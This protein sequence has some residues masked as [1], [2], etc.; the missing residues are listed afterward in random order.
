[1]DSKPARKKVAPFRV[2]KKR[3]ETS[4]KNHKFESFN[5]RIA[6]L[7]IDPI[8]RE[9]GIDDDDLS[10][11]HTH[12]QAALEK[13]AELNLSE[14]YV[15]FAK[16]VKPLCESLP[17]LLHH[18]D[19]IAE[20]LIEAIEQG[21]VI[22]V[23]PL[24]DLVANLAQDL[25]ERIERHIQR[26]ATTVV[27]LS[28]KHPEAEVAEWSFN[29]LTWLFKYLEKLLVPDLRPLYT[30]LAPFLG[31]TR[32]KPY[33]ARFTAESLSFLVRKA[34]V[35]YHINQ[36]PLHDIVEAILGDLCDP[37]SQKNVEMYEQGVVVLFAESIKGAGRSLYSKG[38]AVFREL[39]TTVYRL[40]NED[41]VMAKPAVEVLKGVFLSVLHHTEPPT[42]RP[43]LSILLEK[44][45]IAD[46]GVTEPSLILSAQLILL[47]SSTRKGSRVED[48]SLVFER[49]SG[50][51][52]YLTSRDATLFADASAQVLA[53]F[54][55][56]HQACA[57]DAAIS[58]LK[59]FD[60]ISCS[61]WQDSF[62]GFCDF[63]AEL[64]QDR[65]R[66][67]LL[68]HFQKF[69]TTSWAQCR[70]KLAALIPK[71]AHTGFLLKNSIS[72]P[73]SWQAEIGNQFERLPKA[74][75]GLRDSEVF[76]YNALVEL[77]GA[78]SVE[79]ALPP[80]VS[81]KVYGAL[82]TRLG[83]NGGDITSPGFR[84]LFVVGNGFRYAAA[85]G[86][87]DEADLW[88]LLS[89]LS[90]QFRRYHAFWSSVATFL[91]VRQPEGTGPETEA[92]VESLLESLTSPSH[93]VRLVA[94]EI[95]QT[96]T[97]IR[98]GK[99]SAALS[100]AISIETMPLTLDTARTISMQLRNLASNYV[101]VTADPW[102]RRA[103]PKF[104]FGLL[105]VRMAQ[106]W[107]DSCQALK[108][109]SQSKEGED[110][111]CETAFQWLEAS[112]DDSTPTG[113]KGFRQP[114][115]PQSNHQFPDEDGMV[116]LIHETL[117][118]RSPAV[119]QLESLFREI[120]HPARLTTPFN[121]SQA[122]RVLKAVPQI[123]EKR[124][125]AI[126]PTLLSWAL[127]MDVDYEPEEGDSESPKVPGSKGNSERWSRK[128]QKGM[129][130]LFALFTNPK[131]LYRSA[132]VY[133]ALLSLLEHGDGEIQKSALQALFTWKNPH[134]S[135]Y[136]E[137]LL[138]L[139]DDAKL[140]EQM[141]VFLDAE[142]NDSTLRDEDREGVV[143]IILRLLYGRIISRTKGDRQ[144]NRRTVFVLLARFRENEVSEFITVALG[145]LSRLSLRDANGNIQANELQTESLS[146]RK[147]FGVLNMLKDML[148]IWKTTAAPY[149]SRL[150]DPVVYC[151]VRA[152]REVEQSSIA[153]SNDNAPN[154]DSLTRSIRQV[155]IQCLSALFQIRPEF[156]WSPYM[157]T[158]FREVIDPRV[159]KLPVEMAQGISGL[160]RVFSA[161]S[162]A[163]QIAPFLS[164][165]N[166]KLLPKIADCIG[167]GTTKSEVKRF[168][169]KDIL[170]ALTE[171]CKLA[172]PPSNAEAASV[173]ERYASNFLDR[174][175]ACL[176]SDPNK[177]LLEDCIEGVVQLSEYA[178]VA[179][180]DLLDV[181]AYLLQQPARRVSPRTK[182]KLLHIILKFVP[183]TDL[184]DSLFDKLFQAL[185]SSFAYFNDRDNRAL[186]CQLSFQ[187][188][189]KDE[190]LVGVAKLVQ[191]LNSF[192]EKRLNEPDFERRAA[193]YYI[194][195][196]EQ[197]TTFDLR[198]W[199]LLLSNML[200]FIK[201]E[202][203]MA[204]RASSGMAIRRF[205]EVAAKDDP[206]DAAEH[207]SLLQQLVISGVEKGIRD[208]P[209]LVRAEY[210]S[211]LLHLV[212]YHPQWPVVSD[213][214]VL[215]SEDEDASFFV[216]I[217]HIQKGRRVGALQRL[218]VSAQSGALSS[219]NIYHLL[220]PLIEH[221]I[222]E[223]IDGVLTS[224]SIT[225]FGTLARWMDFSQFRA[226]FRRYIG[227]LH[228]KEEIQVTILKVLDTLSTTF[229]QA[230]GLKHADL[231]SVEASHESGEKMDTEMRETTTLS[232]SMPSQE[233]LSHH[234]IEEVLPPLT[235][236]MHEK[237]ESFVSRR[238][239]L[240]VVIAKLL[241]L[242]SEEEFQVRLPALL[243][244]T[245]NILRSKDQDSRDSTRKALASICTLIGP[246][247]VGFVI[248]ELRTA[249]ARGFYL[250]VLSYTVHSILESTTPFFEPGALDYC[251]RDVV[252]V[253]MED[254][255]GAT[256]KD[257]DA[258]EYLK[259]KNTKKEVKGKKSFDSMQLLA[260]VTSL[261]HMI[262]LIRPLE[263]LLLE[264]LNHKDVRKVEELF[265][266]IEL[267]VLQNTLAQDR[268]VLV[269][270]YEVIKDAS[271]LG[272][273]VK[274]QRSH[275]FVPR[276]QH[277]SAHHGLAKS[278]VVGKV[279][280]FA[281]EIVRAVLRK[282]KHLQTTENIAGFMPI[283]GDALLKEQEDVKLASIRL[284]TAIVSIP[285]PR[286]ESDA[287]V[288]V[289]ESARIVE[290]SQATNDELSQAALKLV[291]AVLRERR[292]AK[293]KVK[294]RTIALLLKKLKP[295]LQ[296]T[297]QQG[298]AFN[299]LR[300]IIGRKVMIPE[301]YEV[302][303]GE[304]G[305]AAISIRDHDRT[306]RDLARGVYFQFLMEYPQT[307]GRFA[308]QL[309]FLIRNLEFRHVEG[310]QSA[311]ET[312]NLL[313]NK[314]GDEIAGEVLREAFWPL[315]A[316]MVNDDSSD[317]R[318]MAAG[319][320]K[321]I[322][323]RADDE[324]AKNFLSLFKKMLENGTKTIQKR[325]AL[326]CWTLYLEVSGEEAKEAPYV[327]AKVTKLLSGDAE[328][329]D[330]QEWQLVYYA[331]HTARLLCKL[332]P[333]T[334]FASDAQPLW[335]YIRAHMSFPHAW[336]KQE[337]AKLI[338]MY[339]A[340]FGSAS[341]G[342]LE[343]LPLV[344][345]GGLK[346]QG[347]DLCEIAYRNLGALRPGASQEM[348]AQ[349]ARN[350]AFLGRCFAANGM[351]W[352]LSGEVTSSQPAS[353]S[354]DEEDVS[355]EDVEEKKSF[356]TALEY[357]FARLTVVLRRE[358]RKPKDPSQ[359][360][361]RPAKL[362][363]PKTAALQLV[364]ALCATLP[365][366]ALTP[367]LEIVL[368]PL[369]HLTDT[370]ITAPTSSDLAF[371]ETYEALVRDA[372]ELMD[373]LQKKLG[374][375]EYV[376]VMQKVKKGM[377]EKRDDRRTKRRIEAI[378]MPEKVEKVKKRK[379]EA[380]KARRKEKG[381]LHRGQRR[382]W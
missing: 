90:S 250:H 82:E 247:S 380:E 41:A 314:S 372:T 238:I 339:V 334:V 162:H 13:W 97:K 73:R 114:H 130:S 377:Q 186:L 335:L 369:I 333:K 370:S 185:C 113:A 22:S 277:K 115:V 274:A 170:C 54:G 83:A 270:C 145:A 269:F 251:A 148:D 351:R 360:L 261:T 306:T 14:I 191:D 337:A 192:S 324:W 307:K 345:S 189:Q 279:M 179:S 47:L 374:T 122:L 143:P 44:T 161:W 323:S 217:L 211:V 362:L 53:A 68:P 108:V 234:L 244:D 295:D 5:H 21:S 178:T 71:L 25:R 55:V 107:E 366:E 225:A 4:T 33:V 151:L 155:A 62:P 381:A 215:V 20:L 363:Y 373:L 57:L 210:L 112:P 291:A 194:I 350:L 177:E 367:S 237:D 72:L 265:R 102:L 200:F 96:L 223:P 92:M 221:Y 294:D 173:V 241:R 154:G 292:N 188:A 329:F 131:V 364:S 262:D 231:K 51:I 249:L 87:V 246:S 77:L 286:I 303:D 322:F 94:L 159:E 201:D 141:S 259:D 236:F 253:I 12:F 147:Q 29:C 140:K 184:P 302:I 121:R 105:H 132:E 118:K 146:Q 280:R 258:A 60:I 142:Q 48:W 336:V 355:D 224:E 316:V 378:T 23:E 293:V 187:L 227:F 24:L 365:V 309:S 214:S 40:N 283:I 1:M 79:E 352:K 193:A 346:L 65:F 134:V 357:M 235:K 338:G 100:T 123:A 273:D 308:K 198:K 325:T 332:R 205:V 88:P 320:V 42:F 160:L 91:R 153:G 106:V 359:P 341:G 298:A 242:L 248:K 209:E 64:G 80:K 315:V 49:I 34:S 310:R 69:V 207:R 349:L 110:V 129:L 127:D 313:L 45:K 17:Q 230:A 256:G 37:S 245:C 182:S 84:E 264:S 317:C 311:M 321:T 361:L 180:P 167:L 213:M 239:M 11:N 67:L 126:V 347:D 290:D 66:S 9:R 202:E 61:R 133:A 208:Q 3:K 266:R 296:V 328:D 228:S 120:H 35:K 81:L 327:Q 257:K 212:R 149:I 330:T 254:I 275:S 31:K 19:R 168:V 98:T 26:I 375:T 152:T 226:L 196:E 86:P 6:R 263:L 222:I 158:I 18:E 165:Y 171:Q 343:K 36:A 30:I 8:R 109:M 76:Y 376:N 56:A 89:S 289:A 63:Y 197:Y 85:N 103:I 233:K 299:L 255:F 124:S 243:T 282:H 206:A 164:R 232:A 27:S 287:A 218:C 305:V 50:Q 301:V 312:L 10:V 39:A 272:Q 319:L 137:D 172:K 74:L 93:D 297:S 174:I 181:S 52:E 32:Q 175:G 166:D 144:S 78:T 300:S 125:R 43:I 117:L 331:L 190:S 220:I 163:I 28:A 353:D 304:D 281:L 95:L 348:A 116:G 157:P 318:G 229:C 59:L 176:R 344:G 156:E 139:L 342:K 379:R 356:G 119:E 219:R 382:G 354:A 268:G 340:D 136:E 203:E 7:K 70:E 46:N 16:K 111:I 135:R 101:N 150:V 199:N 216:N 58:N 75:D 128:D 169:L 285:L 240:A 368:L 267:G 276:K 371:T 99:D 326:Q 358:P 252:S 278:E 195:N 15:A 183:L 2:V 271:T 138:K 38:D 104:C 284:F 204:I 288:Y 260:S